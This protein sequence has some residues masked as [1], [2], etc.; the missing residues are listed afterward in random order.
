MK[1]ARALRL[2]LS[3]LSIGL[4]HLLTASV[5]AA[6]NHPFLFQ[7]SSFAA[8]AGVEP[9]MN[10]PCG[11][12][13]DSAASVYISDY[14][15]DRIA[16]V[17]PNA[18]FKVEIP[19]TDPLN[20][21]CGLA[22]DPAG[23]LYVNS[24][25]GKVT[26]FS[27]SAYPPT[28]STLYSSQTFDSGPATGVAVDPV[29][30]RILVNRRT[31]VAVYEPSGL[32]VMVDGEP[33]KL[34]LGS[35][36][37]GYG[38][39]VSGYAP[40]EGDVYVADAA[41]DTIK[42]FAP[43]D[44]LAVASV[45][46]GKGVPGG[47]FTSLHD[48]VVDIDKTTGHI[49]VTDN[50][51]SNGVEHQRVAVHEFNAAGEY[52]GGLPASPVLTESEPTGM[53]VDETPSSLQG[54]VYVTS[55]NDSQSAVDVFGKTAPARR[56][57]VTLTGLGSGSVSSTPAGIA[58]PGACAAEYTEGEAVRL[59]ATP[60]AGSSFVGW[61][62]D[63]QGTGECEFNLAD[64]K[65]VEAEFASVS[66]LAVQVQGSAAAAAAS[67]ALDP[68]ASP[69]RDAGNGAHASEVVG[70][71][72]IRVR[73]K[74]KMSPRA[75]PRKGLAPVA[76]TVGGQVSSTDGDLPPQLKALRIDINRHGEV[77]YRGLPLCDVNRIQPASSSRALS[78]CRS[79]LVGEGR[80]SASI[81]LSAQEPYPTKG[82]LLVFNGRH[83]GH[84]ALL[85]QIY[86]PYPFATSFVIPFT[87]TRSS[88]GQF[89][90]SLVALLPKAL[91]DW[92]YLTGIEMRL[93]R[94]FR[95]RGSSRSYLS[96]G[97]PAPKG[98]SSVLFPL[99][100]AEF[101]FAG[102]KR[103]SSTVVRSCRAR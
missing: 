52:R 81:I 36:I 80:F 13:I 72:G 49:F 78:A 38:V 20:G 99:V 5:S 39:A 51:Q 64:D 96:A 34:G 100:R 90:T 32:P 54:R 27:P 103:V 65:F 41:T 97:C 29:S 8:P 12:A 76:V 93:R 46:D 35:L 94:K 9:T 15:N 31:Y 98:L 85:A 69:P 14:Y 86:S 87:V 56:L 84:P 55:G 79:S 1:S 24:F 91:G 101:S 23:N 61:A 45:I 95:Y 89:G 22:V 67:A 30:G 92:G 3:L 60:E 19:D 44:P 18:F 37:D 28:T 25:H 59:K 62:G 68:P 53:V 102:G 40:T 43:D 10:G 66:S 88:K 47:G 33:M 11:L 75:L 71:H 7:I 83:R 73:M 82:R 42:V 77:D 16:V 26:K 4:L 74:A 63:C 6:A 70:Q 2:W 17:G 58:C 50:L 57:Q 21:P 48:A